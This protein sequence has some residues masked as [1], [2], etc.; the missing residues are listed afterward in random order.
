MQKHHAKHSPQT[1]PETYRCR[2]FPRL[3]HTLLWVYYFPTM[4]GRSEERVHGW[5]GSGWVLDS[6][7]QHV[8]KIIWRVV[9][10]EKYIKAKIYLK[11]LHHT[12]KW[13]PHGLNWAKTPHVGC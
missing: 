13:K 11:N 7:E 3:L 10:V 2:N 1:L 9:I 4:V 6:N 8:V 5:L 12:D